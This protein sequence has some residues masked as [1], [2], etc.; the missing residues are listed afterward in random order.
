METPNKLL[1]YLRLFLYELFVPIKPKHWIFGADNGI[2]YREG[3]KYLLEYMLEKHKDFKCTFITKN[4]SVYD[5]LQEKGIPCELNYTKVGLRTIFESDCVFFTQTMGDISYVPRNKKRSL[6]YLVHG[7]PFKVALNELNRLKPSI[8]GKKKKTVINSCVS[9]IFPKCDWEDI[10][11]VSATSAFEASFQRRE[12]DESTEVKVLGMPRNDA[13]FQPKRMNKEK[14]L[15]GLDDKFIITYMPTH[16]KYG[17]GSTSPTP[18]K[19]NKEIQKWMRDNDVVLL[20]KQHPNMVK[21]MCNSFENDVIKDVSQKGLDPQVVIYHSNMLITDYSSV[22]IDYLLL[23]RPLVFY[24][25]D[26]FEEKDAGT[27][28]DLRDEF[29]KN[30]CEDEESLFNMIKAAIRNPHSLIPSKEEIHKYH[31]YIDG[32]SCQRYYETIAKLK[33]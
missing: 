14:W 21:E 9:T 20:V 23:E 19:D 2:S 1:L 18:F 24:F 16:R 10:C 12:F 8:R 5:E 29:P 3:S 32:N 30:Y 31:K 6:F 22:W 15:N 26:D 25:Y 13:L 11:F 7:Q 27:Y 4:K 33:Y 17:K 28:Y